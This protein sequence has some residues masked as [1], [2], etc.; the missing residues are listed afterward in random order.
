MF[1]KMLTNL[2]ANATSAILDMTP[3][4]VFAD[5]KLYELELTQLREALSVMQAQG[6]GVVNLPRTPVRLL[7]FGVRW[8]P[9]SLSRPLIARQVGSGRGAKMPSFHIDLHSGRGQSEVD[10]LNGAVV[11]YGLSLGIP[12]PANR[13]LNE[14]LLAITRKELNPESFTHN[15][16]AMVE[17]FV[18]VQKQTG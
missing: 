3:A 1:E 12:T 10:Y 2:L 13:V 7:A 8:L 18:Q 17:R 5:S 4:E 11:R 15:P 9:A 14:T 6:I 16:A